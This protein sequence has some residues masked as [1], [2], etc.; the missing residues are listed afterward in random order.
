M[1]GMHGK[2]QPMVPKSSTTEQY[3]S[4]PDINGFKN[5]GDITTGKQYTQDHDTHQVVR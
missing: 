1:I 5:Y 2:S 3:Y 4:I